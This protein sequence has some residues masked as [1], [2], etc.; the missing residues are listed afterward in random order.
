MQWLLFI[1]LSQQTNCIVNFF[2]DF[3][4]DRGEDAAAKIEKWVSDGLETTD[5]IPT[6]TLGPG[7]AELSRAAVIT[8]QKNYPLSMFVTN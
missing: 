7:G 1:F 6:A 4:S 5:N 2:L 8:S 3:P